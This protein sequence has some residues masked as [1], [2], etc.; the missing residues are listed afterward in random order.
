MVMSSLHGD[1]I[2]AQGVKHMY[3]PAL[4]AEMK[5]WLRTK[6]HSGVPT[7]Q[8]LK[9]HW[10]NVWPKLNA[11]TADRDCF[12]VSQDIRN[13]HSKLVTSKDDPSLKYEVKAAGTSKASCTCH[14][15]QLHYLCKHMMKVVSLSTGHSGAEII[16]ALGTRAGSS[17]QGLGKLQSSTS[18]QADSSSDQMAELEGHFALDSSDSQPKPAPKPQQRKQQ[19]HDSAACRQQMD[20][21]LKEMFS[22]VTGNDELEQHMLSK[23]LQMQGSIASIQASNLTGTAHPMAVL[24]RVKD[25]W[26]NSVKR[27]KTVGLDGFPKQRKRQKPDSSGAAAEQEAQP[28]SKPAAA[29]KKQGPRQQAETASANK[30]NSPARGNTQINSDAAVTVAQAPAAAKPA[31]KRRCG[32]CAT[33]K[34]LTG[35]KGCLRNKAR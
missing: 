30:E 35:K 20:T 9:E 34:N 6:L 15:G 25:T 19:T 32:E 29:K 21:A 26:G 24:D 2:T 8:I 4:S 17:L 13:I 31:S 3:A 23:I 27:K 14:N 1:V 33:C 11:G 7:R 5:D 22:T 28:F 16:Q 10:K 12:L 18:T